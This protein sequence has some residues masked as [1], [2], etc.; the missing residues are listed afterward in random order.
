MTTTILVLS[1]YVGAIIIAYVLSCKILPYYT[2]KKTKKEQKKAEGSFW[3][4]D[5]WSEEK[6]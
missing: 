5:D 3:V 6:N 1:L 4:E 2:R